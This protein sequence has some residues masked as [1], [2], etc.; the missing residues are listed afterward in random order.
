MLTFALLV[1]AHC[2]QDDE[3]DD[4]LEAEERRAHEEAVQREVEALLAK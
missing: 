1:I 3:S 2:L 4:A